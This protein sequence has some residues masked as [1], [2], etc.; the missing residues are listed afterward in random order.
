MVHPAEHEDAVDPNFGDNT[1]LHQYCCSITIR[2]EGDHIRQTSGTPVKIRAHPVGAPG[3]GG[4]YQEHHAILL[5]AHVLLDPLPGLHLPL[6]QATPP[7]V[8]Q[9]VIGAADKTGTIC[10]L[11]DITKVA[12]EALEGPHY[13]VSPNYK[14]DALHRKHMDWAAILVDPGCDSRGRTLKGNPQPVRYKLGGPTGLFA[15]PTLDPT[16]PLPAVQ[17]TQMILG[18]PE[19]T[20]NPAD[21]NEEWKKLTNW[22]SNADPESKLQGRQLMVFDVVPVENWESAHREALYAGLKSGLPLEERQFAP[23]EKDN[24]KWLGNVLGQG[25][26]LKPLK[27]AGSKPAFAARTPVELGVDLLAAKRTQECTVWPDKGWGGGPWVTANV[28]NILRMHVT[29]SSC[30]P[31]LLY[32]AQCAN[33]SAMQAVHDSLSQLVQ[34]LHNAEQRKAAERLNALQTGNP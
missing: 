33:G 20:I 27:G 7:K 16:V 2:F 15:F 31:D 12:G 5:P 10:A 14:L 8:V 21:M 4:A 3:G 22:G 13:V 32:F 25:M 29:T 28:P 30:R 1:E 23:T 18:F 6:G 26:A 17:G 34:D 24:S 11:W 9:F 19:A